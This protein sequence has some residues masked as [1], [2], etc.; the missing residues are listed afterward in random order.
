MIQMWKWKYGA[1]NEKLRLRKQISNRHIQNAIKRKYKLLPKFE[2][3]FKEWSFLI[4]G[5]GPMNLVY[6]GSQKTITH[7]Q[8]FITFYHDPPMDWGFF[9]GGS[10]ISTGS[11]TVQYNINC[12]RKATRM[13]IW[14]I[15]VENSL[16]C[17]CKRDVS[18]RHF[19]IIFT[20]NSRSI[21][22]RCT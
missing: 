3:P 10:W 7:P 6:W 19:L 1:Q 18:Y 4:N 9:H 22:K 15:N 16:S 20:Y 2:Q 12:L 13:K 14:A 5:G 17:E 21:T 11:P 8:K